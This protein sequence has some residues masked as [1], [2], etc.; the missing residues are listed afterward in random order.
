MSAAL[1]DT[2]VADTAPRAQG[3][4]AARGWVES[5]FWRAND[6]RGPRA[7]WL[8]GTV[9]RR[10]DGPDLAEVWLI[11]FAAGSAQPVLAGKQ[12]FPLEEARF[13]EAEG[14][15]LEV[16]PCRYEARSSGGALR[17]S[18]SE[19]AASWDLRWEPVDSP[20][21]P[22]LCLLPSRGLIE[23]RLPKNKLLTPAPTCRV[24]GRLRFGDE[25]LEVRDWLGSF[26]HNWGPAHPYEY[27]WGQVVF[28]DAEGQ[29]T[30]MAEG[31]SGRLKLGPWRTWLLSGLV[32]RRG[33]REYRFDRIVDR[34][35]HRVELSDLRWSARFRG[36]AG[37]ARITLSAR[38]DQVVCLGYHNPDGSLAHCLNSKLARAELAVNP[39]NEDAFTCVS[40]HGAALELLSLR[41]DPR[42]EVV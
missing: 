13:G 37:S 35:N 23:A 1:L 11:R 36:P 39:V 24:S 4:R 30:V 16:G 14:L 42:Y 21:S 31:Y 6:P 2:F 3:A 34:W 20:L 17:G 19:P 10:P 28:A 26:G 5:W 32:V 18:L 29:P 25:E 41:P 8:K 9:L 27:A 22:P 40:E 38:P 7:L 15:E 12:S 33:E